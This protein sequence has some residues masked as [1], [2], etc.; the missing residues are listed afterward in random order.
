M[1]MAT[2]IARSAWPSASPTLVAQPI[3]TAA[4]CALT[5]TSASHGLV[6]GGDAAPRR[7]L[8]AGRRLGCG[9]GVACPKSR[10]LGCELAPLETEPF[11]DCP[12]G[13]SAC[14]GAPPGASAWHRA[15]MRVVELALPLGRGRRLTPL[16]QRLLVHAEPWRCI[17]TASPLLTPPSLGLPTAKIS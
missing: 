2:Q 6:I 17:K 16:G 10:R 3:R 12:P 11:P 8:A 7:V 9:P 1:P 5:L 4:I 14:A 13:P 15:R